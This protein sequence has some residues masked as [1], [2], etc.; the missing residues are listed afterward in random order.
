MIL[1]E[2]VRNLGGYRRFSYLIFQTR[3]TSVLF[4]MLG[5]FSVLNSMW[6]AWTL[7]CLEF[8]GMLGL[9]SVLNSMDFSLSR[10]RWTFLCPEVDGLFSVRK[11]SEDLV[12]LSSR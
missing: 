4:G 12:I 10:S 5:L 6:N 9:F 7:L 2:D 8:Y 1:T 11:D 3:L